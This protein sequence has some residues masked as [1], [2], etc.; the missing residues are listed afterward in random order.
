MQLGAVLLLAALVQAAPG[1]ATAELVRAFDAW[2]R[3]Q[4]YG[5]AATLDALLAPEFR[6]RRIGRGAAREQTRGEWLEHA[7]RTPSWGERSYR[8]AVVR[9]VDNHGFVAARQEFRV[10]PARGWVPP[11]RS[12]ADV[13]EI[14]VRRGGDWQVTE[15]VIGPWG[16]RRW[17]E[18]F[19][20]FVAGALLMLVW[21]AGRRMLRRRY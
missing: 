11:L 20:W 7:V 2:Q 3:A 4:A 13:V 15:R 18:R 8:N 16:I 5:D 1:D 10:R 9:V 14:W 12:S 19:A 21:L 6:A 17:T